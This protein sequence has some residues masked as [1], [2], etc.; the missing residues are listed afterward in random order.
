MVSGTKGHGFK[1]LPYKSM[2]HLL[3]EGPSAARSAALGAGHNKLVPSQLRAQ[4]EVTRPASRSD[5]QTVAKKK[6]ARGFVRGRLVRHKKT[7]RRVTIVRASAAYSPKGTPMHLVVDR[8]G[9][10]FFALE[11]NLEPL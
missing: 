10:R 1:D 2:G 5:T 6:P 9:R 11:K 7:G 8:R 3:Q 4:A